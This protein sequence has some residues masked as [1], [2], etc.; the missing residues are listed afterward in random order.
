MVWNLRRQA[1]G[2]TAPAETGAARNELAP[3]KINLDLLVTGR[4]LD[5]YHELDSLVVFAPVGDRLEFEPADTGGLSLE[6]SGPFAPAVPR[7]GSNL[8]LRAAELLARRT[9]TALSGRIRLDKQLPVGGGLGGGSADAAAALRLLDRVCGTKLGNARL[10]ELGAEL[11]ADVPV[12][13]YARPARMRGLGERLDP[14]RGLPALALLLVNPGVHVATPQVFR[15]LRELGPEREGGL[16]PNGGPLVLAQYL[17]ESR[18]DLEA[19]AVALAPAIGKVLQS[20]RVLEGCLLARMSGSGS[21][22]FGLFADGVRLKRAATILRA[23]VPGWWIEPVLI[24]PGPE[25]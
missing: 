6:V 23:A 17:A 10:R 21:T 8:V 11:G 12:C 16:Q 19:P 24:E 9:G 7:D 14:V 20:L 15:G 2:G 22:C 13:V 4:R 25:S 1:A 3:A 5:G 18:N